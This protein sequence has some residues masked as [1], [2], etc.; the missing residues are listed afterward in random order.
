M[1]QTYREKQERA[2]LE[3]IRALL[4]DCPDYVKQYEKESAGRLAA[5][6]RFTYLKDIFGY[7]SFITESGMY[8]LIS[9]SVP[10]IGP[11]AS[12]IPK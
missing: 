12:L 10:K 11:R 9:T 8:L 6:T 4:R 5:C 7:L 3:K 1:D 2:Y